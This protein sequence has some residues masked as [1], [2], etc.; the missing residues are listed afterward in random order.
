MT[1]LVWLQDE[2]DR[3]YARHV[4]DYVYKQRT[5]TPMN[6]YFVEAINHD[7]EIIKE[8][9]QSIDTS[10]IDPFVVYSFKRNLN[11]KDWRDAN[12]KT[13][14]WKQRV[15]KLVKYQEKRVFARYLADHL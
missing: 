9:E 8:W 2:L 1:A 12:M 15:Y 4:L 3:A 10:E 7:T 11:S 5:Q 6:T 14:K 13:D